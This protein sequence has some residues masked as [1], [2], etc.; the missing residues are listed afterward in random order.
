MHTR[1]HQQLAKC[2]VGIVDDNFFTKKA[3]CNWTL[4]DNGIAYKQFQFGQKPIEWSLESF[5]IKDLPSD[6]F[7]CKANVLN[8]K[9]W[10]EMTWIITKKNDGCIGWTIMC[11]VIKMYGGQ[12]TTLNGWFLHRYLSYFI[13][14][15]IIK[16]NSVK[17]TSTGQFFPNLN[18][19]IS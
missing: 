14:F 9:A 16:S 12:F 13:F 15:L 10:Q 5:F 3:Y 19:F 17:S 8:I 6:G 18:N 4:S 1:I 2:V 7:S 11:Q